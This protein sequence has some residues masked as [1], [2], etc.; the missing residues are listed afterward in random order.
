MGVVCAEEISNVGCMRWKPL[1]WF[2]RSSVDLPRVLRLVI[3]PV[4]VHLHLLLGCTP[5]GN[6]RRSNTG[7]Y[8][9]YFVNRALL[10]RNLTRVFS[11]KT[12]IEHSAFRLRHFQILSEYPKGGND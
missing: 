10:P 2:A 12:K 7:F 9:R 3:I 1:N 5:L 11:I 6:L 4:L 8:I